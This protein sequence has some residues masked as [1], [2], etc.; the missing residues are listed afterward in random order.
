M[1]HISPIILSFLTLVILSLNNFQVQAQ[2]LLLS[3]YFTAYDG[4]STAVPAGWIFNY[5]GNYTSTQSSGVS[6]PNSYKFGVNNATITSPSFNNADSVRFFMKGN[7]ADT[8]SSLSVFEGTDTL[9]M[10]LVAMLK[11]ISNTGTTISLKLM[12]SSTMLRFVYTKSV[13]NVAFD[14][15]EVIQ[16]GPAAINTIE[17]KQIVL[18]PNPA[19]NNV[20]IDLGN[21]EKVEISLY[22]M[23]GKNMGNVLVTDNGKGVYS[24][25]LNSI[26]AGTYFVQIN[27]DRTVTTRRLQVLK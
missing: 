12:S 20:S 21:A 19:R 27:T 16:N 15:F 6:G 17:K 4:T 26:P 9:N 22:N 14:D 23:I 11:P 1:K 7:S 5:N 10:T 18:Y 2:T 25:N 24:L 8:L 3:E 13:G